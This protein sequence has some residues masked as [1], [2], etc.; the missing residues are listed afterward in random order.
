MEC[1]QQCALSTIPFTG[2]HS[3]RDREISSEQ[4]LNEY[5]M[6]SLRTS[7]GINLHHVEKEFGNAEKIRIRE[8]G[9]IHCSRKIDQENGFLRLTDDGNY[10][11][12]ELADLF[13]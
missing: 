2:H 7:S 5:V 4:Q 11:R 13:K 1:G 10:L 9:Q 3:N 8:T 12:M 6:V